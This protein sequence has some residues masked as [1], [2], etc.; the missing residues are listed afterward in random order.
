MNQR[1]STI[2]TVA[3]RHRTAT[4]TACTLLAATITAGAGELAARGVIHDRVAKAAPD[5]GSNM[6]VSMGGAWALRDLVVD[7]HIPQ[8][9]ISSDSARFGPLSRVT[10]QAQL[11]DVHLNSG[12]ATV[13]NTHVRVTVPTQSIASAIQATAPSV[14]VSSVTTDPG[15]G[16]ITAAIGSGGIGLLTLHPVLKDGKASLAVDGLTVFGR[17]VPTSRL[18]MKDGDLGTASGV[19]QTYPLGL[20]ASVADVQP[21]GLHVT[22]TGGPSTL[23]GA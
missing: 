12:K 9:D 20:K 4:I 22:L 14:P 19:K 2:W 6:T 18:G 11:N 23:P 17:S 15:S 8:L 5:L 1:T 7:Q 13:D 10:V 3:R 21:D 16:T